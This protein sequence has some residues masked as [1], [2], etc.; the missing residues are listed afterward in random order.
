MLSLRIMERASMGRFF[1]LN[2]KNEAAR[3]IHDLGGMFFQHHLLQI[4]SNFVRSF[5]SWKVHYI[6]RT[7]TPFPLP[8]VPHSLHSWNKIFELSRSIVFNDVIIFTLQAD[9]RLPSVKGF[10]HGF[11]ISNIKCFCR[12]NHPQSLHVFQQCDVVQGMTKTF[13]KRVWWK[14]VGWCQS[15]VWFF[16]EDPLKACVAWAGWGDVERDSLR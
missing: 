1:K 13:G 7:F 15:A 16:E 2:R 9:D 14:I 12:R 6:A 10:P 3:R 8:T 11:I 5:E 4:S